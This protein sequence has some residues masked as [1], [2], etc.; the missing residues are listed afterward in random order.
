MEGGI[1]GIVMDLVALLSRKLKADYIILTGVDDTLAPSTVNTLVVYSRDRYL[2]NF[3]YPLKG[4]PCEQVVQKETC[5]ISEGV[6]GLFPGDVL[7]ELMGIEGYAGVHLRDENGK[8]A[9][10]LLALFETAIRNPE[11]VLETLGSCA[12]WASV[13]VDRM[14]TEKKLLESEERFRTVFELSPDM[15]CVSN[16][17]NGV[18]IEANEEFYKATGYSRAEVIGKSSLELGLWLHPE[19]CKNLA[20]PI[21][22][23]GYVK[24]MEMEFK[25]KNGST[26]VGLLSAK[27]IS[28]ES[29]PRLLT[30]VKDITERKRLEDNLRNALKKKD[31]LFKELH[32][33]VKN[34]FQ[35]ITSI[36]K[37]QSD[38][39]ENPACR[40][41]LKTCRDRIFSMSAIHEQLYHSKG[42]VEIDFGKFLKN[43]AENLAASHADFSG[44]ISHHVEAEGVILGIESAIPCGMVVNELVSNALKHA[45]P[46]G[47]RGTITISLRMDADDNFEIRVADDGIGIPSDLDIRNTDTLG[48]QLVIMLVERQLYGSLDVVRDKGTDFTVRFRKKAG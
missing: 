33:R 16:I 13:E 47:R 43:L 32:H 30:V 19:E 1:D 38:Q 41:V 35:V 9:G 29:R 24:N 6:A 10:I 22:D 3:Q 31:L 18:F 37:L 27:M 20:D 48:M 42:L 4:T 46:Q 12:D 40:E 21:R 15:T 45:F 36:L 23:S 17:E 8:T 2:E 11:R 34:N 44:V 5:I 14:E 26:G 39:I 7:L 28:V 25:S